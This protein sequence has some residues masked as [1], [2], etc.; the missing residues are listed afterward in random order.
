MGTKEAKV[1]QDM[2]QEMAELRATIAKQ[3]NIKNSGKLVNTSTGVVSDFENL[4]ELFRGDR[5]IAYMANSFG[6]NS[7]YEVF[8]TRVH[9]GKTTERDV[10]KLGS[11]TMTD[12]EAWYNSLVS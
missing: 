9:K 5:L 1:H 4:P 10:F 7:N 3:V 12:L 8:P 2:L 6:Y 11:N